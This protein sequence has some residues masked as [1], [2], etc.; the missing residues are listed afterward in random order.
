IE[1][2]N[3]GIAVKNAVKEARDAAD[4]ITEND[5]NNDAIAEVISKF[6]FNEEH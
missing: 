2:A 4:Y 3:I 1:A 5:N 6:I